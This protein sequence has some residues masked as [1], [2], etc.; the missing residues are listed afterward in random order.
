MTVTGVGNTNDLDFDA[1][2]YGG[3][4]EFDCAW[5]EHLEQCEKDEHD[6]CDVE[7]TV[8]YYS[9]APF[10]WTDYGWDN[11]GATFTLKVNWDRMTYQ[12]ILS[13]VTGLRGRCSLCYPGQADVDADGD[14]ECYL[15][16][17]EY[18]RGE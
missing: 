6:Y 13:P 2:L 7:Q 12:C 15:V 4:E 17:D 14:I 5:Q 3:L 1:L 9:D 10:V 8:C 11:P 18:L 16:P